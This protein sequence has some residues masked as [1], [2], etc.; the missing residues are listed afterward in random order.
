MQ[1]KR[2]LSIIACAAALQ[3]AP[4]DQAATLNLDPAR[5]QITISGNVAGFNLTP[6]GPGSLTTTVGGTISVET[7]PGQIQITGANLDPNI[8][9]NWA[10]GVGGAATSP[11]DLAGEASTFLGRVTG[12]L[13]E[14]VVNAT[15]SPRALDAA[16]QFDAAAIV[17]QFPTNGTSRFD[18]SAPAIFGGAGSAELASAGTNNTATVGTYVQSDGTATLTLNLDAVFRFSIISDDPDTT[19]M[20]KGQLVATGAPAP[21]APMIGSVELVDGQ[22]RFSVTGA[23][24]SSQVEGTTNLKDWAPAQAT[25]SAGPGGTTIYSVGANAKYGFFRVKG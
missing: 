9:G 13:R 11:A 21:S 12:A 1:T 20:L 2:L 19:L 17:F 10:P 8:N 5:S 3:S 15:S 23:S 7:P 22:L 16:G 25:S 4:S 24:A 14:L 6:Q 18:Y